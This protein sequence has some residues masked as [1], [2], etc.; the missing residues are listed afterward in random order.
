M[1]ETYSMKMPTDEIDRLLKLLGPVNLH[2]D[3][4]TITHACLQLRL[5]RPGQRKKAANIVFSDC[6]HISGPTYGGP[7]EC[8]AAEYRQGR[9]TKIVFVAGVHFTVHALRAVFIAADDTESGDV[10]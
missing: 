7:W 4:Y 2:I 5:A 8:A 6:L 9:N 10:E 3:G 1:W